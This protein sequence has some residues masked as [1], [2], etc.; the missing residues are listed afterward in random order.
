VDDKIWK[1]GVLLPVISMVVAI[2]CIVI[3]MVLPSIC[4]G[5]DVCGLLRTIFAF[6]PFLLILLSA[7]S[8]IGLVLLAVIEVLH[9]SKF[10][11]LRKVLWIAAFLIFPISIAIYYFVDRKNAV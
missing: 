11:I 1:W 10:S 2:I 4:A 3:Y 5:G 8:F 6:G 9:S 7:I